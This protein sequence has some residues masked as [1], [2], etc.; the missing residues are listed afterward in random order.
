MSVK[1]LMFIV[2][3]SLYVFLSLYS[4]LSICSPSQRSHCITFNRMISFCCPPP[5]L[6]LFSFFYFE[7]FWRESWLTML[8]GEVLIN[9]SVSSLKSICLNVNGADREQKFQLN[10][11]RHCFR[12]HMTIALWFYITLPAA[13]R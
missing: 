2:F 1:L 7:A 9:D 12:L 6:P 3:S 10:D 8:G 11:F 5:P 13:H 4:S